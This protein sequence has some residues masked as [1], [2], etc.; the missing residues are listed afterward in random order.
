MSFPA[1]SIKAELNNAVVD[2][3]RQRGPDAVGLVIIGLAR[4]FV[5]AITLGVLLGI[6]AI[7]GYDMTAV[8]FA[9]LAAVSI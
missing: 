1:G 2:G 5:A 4:L 3:I 6:G 8:H 9:G 7:F